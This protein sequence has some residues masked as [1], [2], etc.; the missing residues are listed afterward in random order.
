MDVHYRTNK[1]EVIYYLTMRMT[2][3]SQFTHK[4]KIRRKFTYYPRS[5][6]IPMILK[7]ISTKNPQYELWTYDVNYP[8]KNTLISANLIEIMLPI[9]KNRS[10]SEWNRSYKNPSWN[11]THRMCI[12]HKI[13]YMYV[14]G[15]GVHFQQYF[16]YIVAISFIG[17]W[18]RRKSPT[19]LKSLT[20]FI[21]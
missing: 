4:V 16:S 12:V 10:N 11:C 14:W 5:L 20:N 18:N 17:G 8:G 6:P 13:T 3:Q 9:Q 2:F 1:P 19:C 15:L 21:T 7:Q